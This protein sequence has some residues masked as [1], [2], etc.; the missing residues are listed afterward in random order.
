MLEIRDLTKSYGEIAALRGVTMQVAKGQLLGFLGPNGAGKTTTMRSVFGLVAPDSGEVLWNDRRIEARDRLGFGYMP[1]ERGLYPRMRNLEQVAYFGMLHGM[2]RHTANLEAG[3][4]LESFGLA[5]RAND[6]LEELSHGNQQRLQLAA[7]LVHSPELLV[8]DEP[9]A[10]LDPVGV[11]AMGEILASQA[12][13]GTAV[14]FSSHQLDL[15]EDLCDDVVII[16]EGIVALAGAVRELRTNTVHRHVTVE[17]R[18]TA[19]TWVD[20]VPEAAVQ[21]RDG[22]RVVLDVSNGIQLE[23]LLALAQ[24]AGEVLEFTYEPPS[25][26]EVFLDA[27]GGS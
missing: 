16:N 24:A 27:V 26:N 12:A 7:A 22:D 1:E 13:A 14:V 18:D 2:T 10:G 11:G 23:R 19:S 3:R 8:L 6:R 21:S 20:S 25:L 4:W 9:F 15:V 17:V 5:D